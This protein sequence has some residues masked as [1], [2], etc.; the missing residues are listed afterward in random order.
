MV[1][2]LYTT[3]FFSTID[4]YTGV[5]AL[6]D[7]PKAL[8]YSM[9][10]QC[11]AALPLRIQRTAVFRQNSQIRCGVKMNAFFG[12]N[13]RKAAAP[14][15]AVYQTQACTRCIDQLGCALDM[16]IGHT[17]CRPIAAFNVEYARTLGD[18][19]SPN[20]SNIRRRP[21]RPWTATSLLTLLLTPP[22]ITPC[23][24]CEIFH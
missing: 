14:V 6:V 22:T 12:G 3:V 13:N 9:Q 5:S 7:N 24:C 19:T 1:Q 16:V 21:F 15:A 11:A 20:I 2:K 17:R 10:K 8:Q 18:A 23:V 4:W